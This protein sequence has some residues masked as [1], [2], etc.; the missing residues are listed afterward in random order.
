[1]KLNNVDLNKV[2]VFCQVVD[3]GNYRKASEILNVTPSALSQSISSLEHGLGFA[4]FHRVG[5]KLVPTEKGLRLHRDFRHY[6]SGLLRAVQQFTE[7][8]DPVAGLLRVGA[9]FEFAKTQLSPL[10]KTFLQEHP[11]ARIKLTFETPSRLHRLLAEGKLDL[12]FSI[13]PAREARSTRVYQEELVLI[14][15]PRWF[16]KTPSYEDILASPI[17]EYYFNH[18]PIRRWISLHYKRRPKELPIRAYVSS[19]EMVFSLVKQ[20]LGIG[21][22][23]KYL[24]EQPDPSR[25]L[26]ICRPTDKRF[27]DHIWM[28]EPSRKSK[29]ALHA[30]FAEHVVTHLVRQ[31]SNF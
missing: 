24:L 30:A 14:T 16:A 15:P 2:A 1:M 17:L 29:S 13:Y 28:L 20:G 10:L 12:C 25:G 6:H 9:Y 4:L 23:P 7:E 26:E 21:V 8:R 19:A 31:A 22:V 18:Q 27:T 3:S 11:E 5:K